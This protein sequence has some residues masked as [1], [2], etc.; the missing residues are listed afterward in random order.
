MARLLPGS[1]LEGIGADRRPHGPRDAAREGPIIPR[2]RMC[3]V[4]GRT[5]APGLAGLPDRLRRVQTCCIP[6]GDEGGPYRCAVAGQ[7]SAHDAAPLGVTVPAAARCSALVLRHARRSGR[8]SP[9]RHGPS[10]HRVKPA[11]SSASTFSG[12]ISVDL[13]RS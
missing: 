11:A 5:G 8:R 12:T 7:C 3:S 6:I 4:L 13:R 2:A 9:G 10:L 1:R